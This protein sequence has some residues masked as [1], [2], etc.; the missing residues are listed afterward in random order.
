[1]SVMLLCCIRI[2]VRLVNPAKAEISDI[3]F[4]SN[5]RCVKLVSPAKAEMSDVVVASRN[6]RFRLVKPATGEMS[7]IELP[8][9]LRCIT[10]VNSARGDTSDTELN[11]RS[12]A[13]SW[14]KPARGERSESELLFSQTPGLT[15]LAVKPQ[16]FQIG[17]VFKPGQI[18]NVSVSSFKLGQ[19]CH[20]CHSDGGT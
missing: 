4:P 10:L 16:R 7:D 19:I 5:P 15:L 20:I 14:V 11:Q 2:H 3:E 8:T 18:G 1:M 17:C 13:S 12:S 9:R 6:S